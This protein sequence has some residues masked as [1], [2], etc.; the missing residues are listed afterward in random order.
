MLAQRS[1]VY[2]CRTARSS[3]LPL[4]IIGQNNRPIVSDKM[5]HSWNGDLTCSRLC[6]YA[7]L[8]VS[9]FCINLIGND[10]PISSIKELLTQKK[11]ESIKNYNSSDESS[12]GSTESISIQPSSESDNTENTESENELETQF[13]LEQDNKES[14]NDLT[15]TG[16][17]THSSAETSSGYS[18]IVN[19]MSDQTS[20]ESVMD[21]T[22]TNLDEASSSDEDELFKDFRPKKSCLKKLFIDCSDIESAVNATSS[23]LNP[24]TP[25]SPSFSLC[26]S[27][28]ISSP[29]SYSSFSSNASKKRVSFADSNGKEL[30]TIRTMSEPSNCPP[31][32]TSKIVEYF[33]NREFNSSS[34]HT[35]LNELNY[36]SNYTSYG[37]SSSSNLIDQDKASIAVYSLNFAQPAG[38]YLKFRQRLDENKVCLENVVLNR[39]CINGTI[40]V[41]NINFHKQVFIRFSLDKWSTYQDIQAQY[42]P[43]EYYSTPIGPSSPT[44]YSATF[45]EANYQPN[46]KDYD[47]F[48]FQFDLPRHVDASTSHNNSPN[49]TIQ[50]CVCYQTGNE[51]YWD[52]NYGINYEI[53]QYVIGLVNKPAQA[54]SNFYL[55]K[56]K[57]NNYFRYDSAPAAPK[58]AAYSLSNQSSSSSIYY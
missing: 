57:S 42:V 41:K 49:N 58:S 1:M 25:T 22:C 2:P 12:S 44:S 52:N 46:H 7:N 36:Y 38:D 37:I 24:S 35:R 45:Y 33:L 20:Q 48:R 32:L 3:S 17:E 47:T 21:D 51:Q 29:N 27:S 50:F 6:M 53:L 56:S 9:D 28:S 26:S 4:K 15:I 54:K 11:Q 13:V 34:S 31:K 19:E 8:S 18:S 16:S 30:C 23:P 10:L 5:I 43:S 39:F 40:K 55:G 14:N